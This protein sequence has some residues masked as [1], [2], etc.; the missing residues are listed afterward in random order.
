[1]V[2]KSRE[3]KPVLSQKPPLRAPKPQQKE[4]ENSLP[5]I[6]NAIKPSGN[7]MKRIKSA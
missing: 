5:L 6:K 4:P 1:M 3:K 7:S 2:D